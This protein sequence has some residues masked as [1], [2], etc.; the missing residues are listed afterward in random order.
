MAD[1]FEG[2]TAIRIGITD[3]GDLTNASSVVIKYKLYN[4]SAAR[5]WTAIVDNTTN[6]DVYYNLTTSDRL[7]AGKYNVWAVITWSD[8][9]ISIGEVH[10]LE[11]KKDGNF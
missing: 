10:R 1:I 9:R 8:N 6:G 7:I 4:A 2:Q 5:E 3:L 11:I